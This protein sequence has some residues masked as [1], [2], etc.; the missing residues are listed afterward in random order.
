MPPL[1]VWKAVR[2]QSTWPV[3][4]PPGCQYSVNESGYM[5]DANFEQWFVKGF[6]KATQLVEKPILLIYDGHG[7]HI[8][9]TTIKTAIDNKVI[10]L[11]LPP[12]CSHALQPLDVACFAPLKKAWRNILNSNHAVTKHG[13]D[14][15]KFAPCLKELMSKL[16]PEH[17]VAGF[18][19]SGLYP[20]NKNAV[21]HRIVDLQQDEDLPSPRKA[22][23]ETVREVFS[24]PEAAAKKPGRRRRVQHEYGEVLTAEEV[25]D[26]IRRDDEHRAEKKRL[27]AL[28]KKTDATARKAATAARKAE[29]AA[30]KAK[31]KLAKAEARAEASSRPKKKKT[32]AQ[33][34]LAA[35]FNKALRADL[36]GSSDDSSDDE[37]IDDPILLRKE[38]E[39]NW[40]SG[41]SDVS[42]IFRQS[43]SDVVKSP[44]PSP[45]RRMRSPSPLSFSSRSATPESVPGSPEMVRKPVQ[46]NLIYFTLKF[47]KFCNS[48]SIL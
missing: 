14:K 21:N 37:L 6:V 29:A 36:A 39:N 4:G 33:R 7:S 18:R 46:V 27:E 26:R 5:M 30:K 8:T 48:L 12:H 45:R 13:L 44:V 42:D 11:A 15:V 20:L 2:M 10:I 17:G 22:L 31:D 24:P 34:N 23:R 3:G 43:D 28:K 9:Y 16:K 38:K 35:G 47:L 1:V 41:S 25:A 40:S 19:G 32:P